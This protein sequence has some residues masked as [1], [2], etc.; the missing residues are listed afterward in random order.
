MERFSPRAIRSDPGGRHKN[1]ID[2]PKAK[3]IDA[4]ESPE[5][6]KGHKDE[7]GERMVSILK[8]IMEFGRGKTP[9]L[10]VTRANSSYMAVSEHGTYLTR[11]KSTIF[12][13]IG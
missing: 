5:W 11:R 9:T 12:V 4:G 7:Y 10:V 8:E 3:A 2:R 13:P 6:G 1:V